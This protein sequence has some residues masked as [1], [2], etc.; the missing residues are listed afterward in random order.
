MEDSL[1][2]FDNL[3]DQVQVLLSNRQVFEEY[4]GKY[5]PI[6]TERYTSQT[7]REVVKEDADPK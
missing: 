7:S 2:Y 5:V 4:A 6:T 1:S 3:L